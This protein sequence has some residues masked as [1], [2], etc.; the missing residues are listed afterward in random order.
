[1]QEIRQHPNKQHTVE[2]TVTPPPP[3]AALPASAPLVDFIRHMLPEEPSS[4][5]A[6]P[7][8]QRLHP[9][10]HVWA[11][12]QTGTPIACIDPTTLLD[13]VRVR[14]CQGVDSKVLLATEPVTSSSQSK[15]PSTPKMSPKEPFIVHPMM[16]CTDEQLG[17]GDNTGMAILLDKTLTCHSQPTFVYG[18][19][20]LAGGARFQIQTVECWGFK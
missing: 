8:P 6:S 5:A 12:D 3:P 1:L 2:A 20:C 10:P 11:L 17:I 14:L 19:G 16:I 7:P 15:T 9:D 13:M 4:K 18:N